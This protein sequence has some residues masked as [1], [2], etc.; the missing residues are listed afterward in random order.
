MEVCFVEISTNPEDPAAWR[1]LPGVGAV[2]VLTDYAP[3]TYW[4][5]AASARANEQSRFT[6]AVSVIVK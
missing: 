5:R 6:E 3:G 4:V 1:R 2:H